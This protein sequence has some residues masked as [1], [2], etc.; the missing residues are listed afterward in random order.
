MSKNIYLHNINAMHDQNTAVNSAQRMRKSIEIQRGN[1]VSIQDT[2][3]YSITSQ[4]LD[5]L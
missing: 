4:G 5:Y 3:S 2:L 1:A